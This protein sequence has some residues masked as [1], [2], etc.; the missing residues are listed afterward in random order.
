MFIGKEFQ[1]SDDGGITWSEPFK[2]RFEEDDKL[3]GADTSLVRL[4]N[5][6]VGLV[7]TRRRGDHRGDVCMVFYRFYGQKAML[8]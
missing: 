8:Y 1:T 2:G 4:S 6:G 5:G 3:R 7:G